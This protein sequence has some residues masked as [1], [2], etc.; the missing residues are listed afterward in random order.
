VFI[1]PAALVVA[2]H[3]KG[4]YYISVTTAAR[5]LASPSL[6]LLFTLT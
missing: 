2:T 5:S 3:N 1:Y 6:L 4:T